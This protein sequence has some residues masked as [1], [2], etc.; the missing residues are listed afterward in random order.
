MTGARMGETKRTVSVA[1]LRDLPATGYTS[2]QRAP[3]LE[4]LSL[5]LLPI[6]APLVVRVFSAISPHRPSVW[7]SSLLP[8]FAKFCPSR[9]RRS[10]SGVSG[11]K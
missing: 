9:R 11:E 8:R 1:W 7:P 3:E 4:C 6:V 5:L 10:S 2:Q